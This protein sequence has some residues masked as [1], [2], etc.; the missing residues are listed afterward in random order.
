MVPSIPP[1]RE[2]NK[3]MFEKTSPTQKKIENINKN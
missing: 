3:P 1:L 2:E